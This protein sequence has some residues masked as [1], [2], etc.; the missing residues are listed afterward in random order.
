MLIWFVVGKFAGPK[1]QKEMR[2]E[3]TDEEHDTLQLYSS[4]RKVRFRVTIDHVF[5]IIAILAF[6]AAGLLALNQY[7][8]IIE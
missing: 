5:L 2:A 1:L 3:T 6:I 7:S 4:V 8:A